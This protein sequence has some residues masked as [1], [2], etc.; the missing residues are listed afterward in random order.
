MATLFFLLAMGRGFS[1]LLMEC[2]WAVIN[3]QPFFIPVP[4]LCLRNIRQL[5]R[6]DW[7]AEYE[8]VGRLSGKLPALV[9]NPPCVADYFCFPVIELCLLMPLS[10]KKN[11]YGT[12]EN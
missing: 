7:F 6:K 9:N 10:I 5:K 8:H 4:L 3:G 11:N 1:L 12:D 2:V